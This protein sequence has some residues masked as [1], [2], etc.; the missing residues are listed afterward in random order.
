MNIVIQNYPR[1]IK[2]SLYIRFL[3]IYIPKV[4]NIYSIGTY[5]P[6]KMDI[7]LE[8]HLSKLYI[9]KQII[10]SSIQ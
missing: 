5:Y 7:L 4:V 3:S 8:K 1:D 9:H 2:Q 10:S 6:I